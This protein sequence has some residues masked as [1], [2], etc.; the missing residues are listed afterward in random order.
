MV[1][2]DFARPRLGR[3]AHN[4]LLWKRLAKSPA[5]ARV[6]VEV[7]KG[8]NRRILVIAGRPGEGPLTESTAAARPF[9]SGNRS[10][11]LAAIIVYC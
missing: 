4:R 3:I 6:A 10:R 9:G 8:R 1:S 5:A 2:I 7:G 11:L